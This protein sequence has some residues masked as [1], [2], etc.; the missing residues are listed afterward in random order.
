MRRSIA[1]FITVLGVL[2]AAHVGAQTC[3]LGNQTSIVCESPIAARASSQCTVSMKN[4]GTADCVG[5]WTMTIGTLDPGS[6]SAVQGSSSLLATCSFVGDVPFPTP[7]GNRTQVNSAWV[8][9]GSG[10]L[11]PGATLSMTGRVLPAPSFSDSTFLAGYLATYRRTG[12]INGTSSATSYGSVAIIVN[13]CTATPTVAGAVPSGVPYAV[14]WNATATTAGY[15]IQEATKQDFSDAVMV[16][17]PSTSRQFQHTVTG[18]TRFYYRVRP[19]VCGGS[20][21]TFGPTTEIVVLPQQAATSRDFDIVVPLGTT[22]QVSQD[23]RFSGLT[24]GATFTASTDKPFLTLT[25]ASGTVGS[26]GTVTL[27]VK[28]SPA[29]LPVGA[30]TGTVSIVVTT[31]SKGGPVPNDTKTVNVPVSISLVTPVSPT[32]KGAPPNDALI[33]P[34]VAHLEGVVPFRSDVRITNGGTAT[35]TYLISFTPSGIDGT[36]SGKQTTIT[37]EA[38]QTVALNDVLKD[39]FGFGLPSDSAGGVL[40]IRVIAGSAATTFVSSRTY[41]STPDGTYGQFIPAVPIARF[42]KAAGGSLTLTQIAQS[43]AFRTNIGLVEGLGAA[44]SGRLRVFDTAGQSLG[45][46]PFTLRPFEFVQLSSF[47]ASRGITAPDARIEVVVDSATGGVT[48]W[49]SVLDQK[50]QDPLL[51]SPIQTSSLS[52]N[53]Y[54]LPGMADFTSAVSNFHSDIRVF[55][56][57]AAPVSTT[58]TFYPQG[59]PTASIVRAVNVAPGEIKVFNNV[60]P[61][62]FGATATGGAI[63][64]ATPANAP[65]VVS[66]RTYS[67]D[68]A[69]GGTFGQ[70]IPAVTPAEGVGA[71]DPPLQI[72]QLEQSVNFRSNV[73]LNELTG[74]PVTVQVS[75]ILPD[76]K[77]AISTEIPLL[78]NEFRQLNSVIN[79]LNPGSTYNA[80]ITIK[81]VSG[82]GRVTAYGSVIDYLTSDPTYVPAQK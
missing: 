13:N 16:S 49:A 41:A 35:A 53:R 61:S 15:E 75:L 76:S 68:E 44:A 19:V 5:N 71:S 69:K 60:L 62:L 79:S 30:N 8:C 7:V 74:N 2:L 29:N 3:D 48:T 64:V 27:T 42:L 78:A 57:S 67:N 63:V 28:G 25:P 55:N 26:N 65:L 17:E 23:V 72:L 10:A 34:A 21:G 6:V 77:A 58:M 14:S 40:D 37:V 24:P 18:A 70:F 22:A 47:L 20:A 82:T 11:A 81:V 54:V 45:E 31:S 1:V 52:A 38:G 80:R 66:G 9:Q 46:F 4:V 32:A 56:A 39:F 59:N 73:G 36:T 33:V 43:N 51:V 12:T 50:T